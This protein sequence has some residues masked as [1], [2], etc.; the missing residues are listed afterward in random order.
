[1]G[2]TF[3]PKSHVFIAILVTHLLAMAMD[4]W[5]REC[6]PFRQNFVV[7]AILGQVENTI[8][9]CSKWPSQNEMTIPV[10][11]DQGPIVLSFRIC[12]SGPARV[13]QPTVCGTSPHF[14]LFVVFCPVV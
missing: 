3:G 4:I 7:V 13:M 14:V 9:P 12:S 1:M 8:S 2:H 5:D 11:Y 10:A 6:G